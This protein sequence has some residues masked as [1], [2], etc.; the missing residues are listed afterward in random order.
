M[1][2]REMGTARMNYKDGHEVTGRDGDREGEGRETEV[3]EKC[4]A[5]RGT[6]A[7]GISDVVSLLVTARS[8]GW[9]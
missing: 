7:G 4:W 6:L 3:V 2:Q 1:W 5:Q 8:G 9:Q